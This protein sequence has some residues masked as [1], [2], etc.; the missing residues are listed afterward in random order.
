MWVAGKTEPMPPRTVVSLGGPPR[1]AV[2]LEVTPTLECNIGWI[3]RGVPFWKG[4][5]S[6]E[7]LYHLIT[8]EGYPT[9]FVVKC[10]PGCTFLTHQL[11]SNKV[12]CTNT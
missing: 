8:K 6:D 3:R 12:R 7:E 5:R 4:N 11:E 1:V 9:Y 10:S 2:S